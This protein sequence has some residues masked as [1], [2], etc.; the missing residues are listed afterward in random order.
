MTLLQVLQQQKKDRDERPCLMCDGDKMVFT[1]PGKIE[2]CPICDG[3]GV[4]K[5]TQ[6]HPNEDQPSEPNGHH[7]NQSV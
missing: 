2:I 6:H 7:C 3:K 4:M 5:P 1:A